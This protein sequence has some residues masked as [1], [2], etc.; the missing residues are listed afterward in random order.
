MEVKILM[1]FYIWAKMGLVS[2]LTL[3]Y[4]FEKYLY[5][6]NWKWLKVNLIFWGKQVV[7]IK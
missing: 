5:Y 6:S 7:T 2:Q 1:C 4:F 3:L